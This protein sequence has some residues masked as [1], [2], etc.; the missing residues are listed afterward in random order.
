MSFTKTK[1][2]EC[3]YKKDL[4]QSCSVLEHVIE[5]NRYIHEKQCRHDEIGILQK[6]SVGSYI[7]PNVDIVDVESDLYGLT[8]PNTRCPNLKYN[9]NNECQNTNCTKSNSTCPPCIKHVDTHKSCTEP[10][11]KYNE[12]VNYVSCDKNGKCFGVGL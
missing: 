1:Y 2:D 9:K 12:K 6:N 4:N 5:K 8:R 7:L 10:L 11:I 3:A